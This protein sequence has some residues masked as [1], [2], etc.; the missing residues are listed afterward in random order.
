MPVAASE[1]TQ[2]VCGYP[3][4]WSLT[5]WAGSRVTACVTDRSVDRAGVE[6]AL[7][8]SVT[9]IEAAQVHGGS[10]AVIERVVGAPAPI[11]GCDA[12][13]TQQPGAALLVRSADCLPIVFADPSRG[14][15][16]IAHAG[17]RGL[18]VQLPARVVAAFRHCYH[19]APGELRVAIGPAI[20]A[21]CYEVGA[22]FVKRFGPFVQ[23]RGERHT[24]DLVGVAVDQLMRCGV[25]P[26]HLFD[27][28]RCT[29][30]EADVWF[31]LRREGPSTGCLC[32]VVMVRP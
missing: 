10:L 4:L 15:V 20:R 13:L 17:W 22:E 12:L 30:C 2:F 29:A 16:G 23:P 9:V 31:S 26:A 3:G 11:P 18:A 19:S 5:G 8:P 6:R 7:P 32:S 14:A 24:C 21:C 1:A 28:R 25:R 27:S